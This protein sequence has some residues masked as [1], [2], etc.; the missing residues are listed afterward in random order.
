MSNFPCFVQSSRVLSILLLLVLVAGC[1]K[2]IDVNLVENLSPNEGI[3]FGRINVRVNGHDQNWGASGYLE[4]AKRMTAGGQGECSVFVQSL[5]TNEIML[6]TLVEDGSFSWKLPYGK[7]EILSFEW[8][9][10]EVVSDKWVRVPITAQFEI[11]PACRMCYLGT[12]II[13]VDKQQ[14]IPKHIQVIDERAD[15]TRRLQ[16]IFPSLPQKID[17]QLLQGEKPL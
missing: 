8:H 10:Y 13:D 9:W 14:L 7:Y 6:S 3:A 5:T 1:T 15:A 16:Q 17:K 11:A 4:H 12:M 2:V